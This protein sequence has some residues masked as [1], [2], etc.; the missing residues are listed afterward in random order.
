MEQAI[1]LIA[2]CQRHKVEPLPYLRNVL[3][4]IVATRAWSDAYD[5]AVTIARDGAL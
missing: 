1:Q 4:R 2:I 3:T 5:N